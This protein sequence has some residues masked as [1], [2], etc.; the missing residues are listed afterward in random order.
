MGWTFSRIPF[1][2]IFLWI[3]GKVEN[4]LSF[5]NLQKMSEI[6]SFRT[7]EVRWFLD[8][9]VPQIQRWF[10]E[11]PPTAYTRESREDIYLVLPGRN[12]LG[13]KFRENRLELKFRL[14]DPQPGS[15]APGLTGAFESWEKLGLQ[16]TPEISTA[17]LPA[18]SE[19]LRLPA[20]KRRLATQIQQT[21]GGITYH[22][23]GIEIPQSV[24]L[25]YTELYVYGSDWYT[26]GLEWADMQGISLPA[27]LLSGILSPTVFERKSS[28]GYPEFLQ[29]RLRLSEGG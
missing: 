16:T 21:G 14:G 19:A 25:E 20:K 1:A 12:D 8:H 23:L 22:P 17:A 27:G 28:M 24:Q 11:L 18:T 2:L 13:L 4:F 6:L 9:P 7:R 26:I 3:G 5:R 15:I 29:K 10:E